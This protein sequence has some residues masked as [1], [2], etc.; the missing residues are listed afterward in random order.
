MRDAVVAVVVS[1]IHT[2][3][4]GVLIILMNVTAHLPF[5]SFPRIKKHTKEEPP[6]YFSRASIFIRLLRVASFGN[7]KTHSTNLVDA[8]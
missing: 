5:E 8:R 2:H 6:A 7:I 4:D 1:R 3:T